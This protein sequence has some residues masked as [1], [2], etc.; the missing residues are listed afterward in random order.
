MSGV[1][2]SGPHMRIGW[3]PMSGKS[4]GP[5]DKENGIVLKKLSVDGPD[6]AVKIFFL[7]DEIISDF[8]GP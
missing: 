1:R 5:W 6:G 3:L 2:S 8:R 4:E 7:N